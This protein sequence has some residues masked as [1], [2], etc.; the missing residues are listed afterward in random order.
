GG[1]EPMTGTAGGG[2][3]A[4]ASRTGGKGLFLVHAGFR[5]GD[6]GGA[7]QL[8][9][10]GDGTRIYT[11]GEVREGAGAEVEVTGIEHTVQFKPGTRVFDTMRLDLALADGRAIKL[12]ARAVGRPWVYRGGGFDSG[13]TDGKGQGVWRSRDLAIEVDSYDISDP[14]AV[15][16]P[17]GTTA[18]PRHREQL[19][20]CTVNGNEGSA[21]MPMFVIGP[22]P[23]FGLPDRG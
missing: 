23:R 10:D 14:E 3:V 1:F 12:D 11:E 5:A 16:M 15:I 22:Q 17:D 19:A 4:S 21:Y 13:F 7:V 20:M 18:F 2:G 9:E 6:L 8:I